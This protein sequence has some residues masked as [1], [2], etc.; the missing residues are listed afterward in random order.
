MK[1]Q[2]KDYLIKFEIIYSKWMVYLQVV[3]E[4][5]GV[6]L[7]DNGKDAG[8]GSENEDVAKKLMEEVLQRFEN[9]DNSG[10]MGFFSMA[11]YVHRSLWIKLQ[12][13]WIEVLQFKF[14]ENRLSNSLKYN[15]YQMMYKAQVVIHLIRVI[16]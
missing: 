11:G 12:I 14:F 16:N 1:L 5:V 4:N 8:K 2:S 3:Y 10:M 9:V 13:S 7:K 6:L 15:F